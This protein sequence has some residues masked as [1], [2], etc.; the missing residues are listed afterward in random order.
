[1]SFRAPRVPI[2]LT[3]L[4]MFTILHQ[5]AG[6]TAATVANPE[7]PI[8]QVLYDPGSGEDIVVPPGFK[9]SVFAKT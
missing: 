9:V 8:E 7:C 6:A 2:M 1:M 5:P 4:A 3:A